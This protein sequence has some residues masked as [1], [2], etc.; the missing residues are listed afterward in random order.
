MRKKKA[1]VSGLILFSVLIAAIVISAFWTP[2][3]PEA[4]VGSSLEAPSAA[5]IFGTDN[6]GRDIFSRV[7][8]GAGTTLNVGIMTVTVGAVIGISIGALTAY[9]GGALDELIMRVNDAITAFPS[10]LLALVII[11]VL[12]PEKTSNLVI[13]LGIAFIPSFARVSR[14]AFSREK[15]QNYVVSARLMGAGDGRIIAAHILPNTLQVLLPAITIGFNNAVLAEASMS[16]LGIGVSPVDPSLG[17]M[18]KASQSYLFSAPWYAIFTG[19]AIILMVLSVGLI[20]DG[21]KNSGRRE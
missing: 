13:S 3:D 7:M 1:L 18:L 4:F 14:T 19:A 16:Y 17:F 20:G 8:K 15:S 10:V 6:F 2:Y 21:I 5:H 12:G 9:Y 11:S